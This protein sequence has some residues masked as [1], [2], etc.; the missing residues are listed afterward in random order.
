MTE[1][2]ALSEISR[3]V[4]AAGLIFVSLCVFAVGAKIALG[5]ANEYARNRTRAKSPWQVFTGGVNPRRDGVRDDK[6]AAGLAIKISTSQWVEQ[7][8][9]SDEALHDVLEH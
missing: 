3:S 5:N 7:G 9:F 4:I 6:V 1:W 8:R 2:I